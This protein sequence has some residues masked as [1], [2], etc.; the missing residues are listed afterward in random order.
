MHK[1]MLAALAKNPEFNSYSLISH[2]LM[3]LMNKK[4]DYIIRVDTEY[5]LRRDSILFHCW[6]MI[7]IILLNIRSL[8][9]SGFH[10]N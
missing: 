3:V 6:N 9:N 1:L 10:K 5:V 4:A 7:S 2:N 8:L